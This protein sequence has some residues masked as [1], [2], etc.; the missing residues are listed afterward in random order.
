M[1]D[2]A[3]VETGGY[4]N[5]LLSDLPKA[6]KRIVI[7]AMIVL[8]GERTAPIF[9]MLHDALK[10]GVKVTI[11]LDNYTRLSYLY[12]LEPRST[13]GKR[14]RQTFAT[15]EDLGRQGAKV[16]CYGKLGF[17]PY[18]GRCHVK[19][20]IVDNISYS[21]G[22]INFFDQTFDLTD[23]MLRSKNSKIADCLEQLV[24]RI[25]KT[26]PPLLDGEVQIDKGTSVLFDGGRP[27]QS[28]IY[29]RA[30]ELSAQATR[31]LYVS[32]MTPSGPLVAL[33]NET[34]T[35]LYFNRP[36]Q[37]LM[38][39]SWGQAFDQ[40]KHRTVNSY[41]GQDFIH[42]KFILFELPGGRKALLSG[43]NNF[44]YRGVAFGTQEIGVYSTD[45]KLWNALHTF[46]RTHIA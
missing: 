19:I 22:G 33:L 20:T 2:L 35:T 8:W 42:A 9:A 15:L 13:R 37:M 38:I 36:E 44:S 45:I 46:Y 23:Y 24:K 34:D 18:K 11:L 16:H 6:R 26:R 10:R 39:D 12:G 25:G 7:A 28:L 32:Q 4:Y 27:K 21:F 43:S 41:K 30:C 29:E 31:V 14:I 40:Q 5:A 1:S 3:L 17:P